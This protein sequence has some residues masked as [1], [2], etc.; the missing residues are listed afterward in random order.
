MPGLPLPILCHL[1]DP[2][3]A[4]SPVFSISGPGSSY[5]TDS[6]LPHQSGGQGAGQEEGRDDTRDGRGSPRE[7]HGHRGCGGHSMV[8]PQQLG[9]EGRNEWTMNE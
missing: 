4:S 1:V 9:A 6:P 5:T 3:S 7:R 2:K 8:G